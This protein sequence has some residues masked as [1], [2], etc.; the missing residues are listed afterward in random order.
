M[1]LTKND[2]FLRPTAY[3]IGASDFVAERLRSIVH[4]LFKLEAE[5]GAVS[6][7]GTLRDIADLQVGVCQQIDSDIEFAQQHEFLKSAFGIS[8]ENVAFILVRQ[9]QSMI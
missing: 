9:F 3:G 2:L 1:L 5:V 8:K 6:E 4:H 7:A